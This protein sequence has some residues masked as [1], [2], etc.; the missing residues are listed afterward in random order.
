MHQYIY[1]DE[2]GFP[3]FAVMQWLR[4]VAT[5]VSAWMGLNGL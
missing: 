5:R 1:H 4:A 2:D 3:T